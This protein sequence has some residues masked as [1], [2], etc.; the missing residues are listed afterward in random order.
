MSWER[1]G[2]RVR[3]GEGGENTFGGF[4]CAAVRRGEEVKSVIWAEEGTEFFTSYFGLGERVLAG[5][6]F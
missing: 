2:G 5:R 3:G 4:T 6:I 1:G